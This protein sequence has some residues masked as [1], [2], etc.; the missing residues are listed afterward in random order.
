MPQVCWICL[1]GSSPARPLMC[2]CKCPRA[3][4]AQCIARWQLQSAGSRRERYCDFC[5]ETLPDW[6]ANLAPLSHCNV[7]A[8]MN[9]NF[10]GRTYS[11]EV[12]PGPDGYRHFTEAIR[13]AFSLPQESLLNITFTCDEPCIGSLLTLNGPGAYDA[14]VHCA[15]VSASR[16]AS[17]GAGT[18]H[19]TPSSPAFGS[20]TSGAGSLPS[21]LGGHASSGA[22]AHSSSARRSTSGLRSSL[23]AATRSASGTAASGSG[24]GSGAS[25]AG[26][27]FAAGDA[28]R[29]AGGTPASGEGAGA[30]TTRDGSPAR[31]S[32]SQA[33]MAA[34]GRKFRSA[35]AEMFS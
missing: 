12:K 32:R 14:A 7:P 20:F 26:A 11:F 4:H 25:G 10:D 27:G 16:R 23:D 17:S 29:V 35:L 19:S 15:A 21:F 1:D 33:A 8:V 13:R 24:T 22:G 28:A 9:V 6:K 30:A 31:R 5:A 2:P 34:L 3:V 18:P